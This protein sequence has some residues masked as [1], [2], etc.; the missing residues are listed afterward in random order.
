MSKNGELDERKRKILRAII[1]DYVSTAEPIGSRSIA[2]KHELGFSSATIRNEMAD[3]E[4]MGYLIQPHTSAGRIPSD[5]GY[6][7]YVDQLM[8]AKEL[9]IKE[10][11][12]IK[13]EMEVKIDELNQL[14]KKASVIMSGFTNYTSF[15]TSPQMKKTA[16]KAI[17]LVPIGRG[18]ALVVIV[19]NINI[20]RNSVINIPEDIQPDFLIKAS[21]VL[22]EKLSGLTIEEIN[23]LVIKEIEDEIGDIREIVI[24]VLNELVECVKIADATEVYLEGTS[25][26]LSYP[27]FNDVMR[28]KEFL[29]SLEEKKVLYSLMN[30]DDT[31]K[32]V[33]IQIGTENKIKE[34]KGCSLITT[35]YRMGDLV[36]GSIG[37]IGP[38]RMEY[39][40]VISAVE[41]I[42][43]KIN[44]E[45]NKFLINEDK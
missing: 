20:I 32:L 36:I 27:E 12:R 44:E 4:E 23:L 28:A 2:K 45:I 13:R 18:K 6:R 3:L 9:S 42:G 40:K 33:N 26:I 1:D 15:A 7:F 29:E 5:K 34:I 16:L 31:N 25:N 37:I 43:R 14:I 10:M 11:A 17:Q 41:Y 8:N 39:S 22:N 35:T 19:T 30:H 24:K 38:T 21:N